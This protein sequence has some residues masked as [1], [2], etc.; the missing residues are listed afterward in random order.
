MLVYYF[1]SWKRIAPTLNPAYSYENLERMLALRALGWSIH[2]L[3]DEFKAPTDTVRFLC[4]RF[5]L[6]GKRSFVKERNSTPSP[7][8]Q[9]F[10]N[11]RNEPINRGKNYAEYVHEEKERKWRR[12]TQKY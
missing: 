1:K 9:T 4:R 2:A 11:E 10:H 7:R 8:A 5:G 3:A 6:G 12:L